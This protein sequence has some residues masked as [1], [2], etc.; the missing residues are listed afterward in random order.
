MLLHQL[1]GLVTVVELVRCAIGHP[2]LG[3]DENVVAALSAERIG[4]DGNGLQ[5]NVAV[6]ARG[7]AG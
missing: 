1:G 5:V 6:V 7:L 2:A 4:V 3:E